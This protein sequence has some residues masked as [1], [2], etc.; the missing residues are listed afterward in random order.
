MSPEHYPVP[1][2]QNEYFPSDIDLFSG[3]DRLRFADCGAYRGDT[4][5]DVLGLGRPVEYIA[6]F[7]PDP[8]NLAKLEHAIGHVAPKNPDIRFF[9]FNMGVWSRPDL[10][11]FN[12][13]SGSSSSIHMGAGEEGRD[14]MSIPVTSLD[15]ALYGAAPNFIKMDIEGAEGEALKGC[16]QIIE[17]YNPV[18]AVCV[19]HKPR[20]LWE[21]PLFIQD[22]YPG[23]RMYLRLHSHLG[24]S[25]VL[26][27][28]PP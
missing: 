6:S 16:R 9:V 5:L 23:Y 21:L 7:E 8:A 10:L 18:M 2:G 11:R 20:D 14:T 15:I 24:T 22:N 1:D 17:R 27:C 3:I 25:T 28:V 26:Y 12:C 4:V 13:N 19:Y